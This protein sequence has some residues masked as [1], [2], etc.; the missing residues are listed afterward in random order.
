M[1]VTVAKPALLRNLADFVWTVAI[2]KVKK[3]HDFDFLC[4]VPYA[5]LPVTTWLSVE[6][7]EPML[8]KRKEAKKYGTKK[9]I[10]GDFEEGQSCL[11]VEDVIT[12]GASIFEAT[13]ALAEVGLK[14]HD[15]VVLIDREQGGREAI[16]AQ[17]F[18]MHSLFTITQIAEILVKRGRLEKDVFY[19]IADYVRENQ[20]AVAQSHAGTSVLKMDFD[21]RSKATINKVSYRLLNLM[22]AK[23]T[24]LCVAVDV[25]KSEDLLR[26]ADAVGP[27][28]CMLKTHIEILEDFTKE[29][30][31]E[32][33]TLAKKYNFL[34][35][36]DSKFG[37]IGNTVKHQYAHGVHR[38]ADW[39][40]L[41]TAHPVPGAGVIDALREVGKELEQDRGILLVVEMS[42]KGN[43]ANQHYT[44]KGCDMAMSNLDVVSGLISQHNH[45][46]NVPGL[47]TMTPGVKLQKG[48]DDLGQ[49]YNTPEKVICE[50][51]ADI[52]I[53]GRGVSQAE[54]PAK[55]AAKYKEQAWEAFQHRLTNL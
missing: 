36:Q 55:E 32:L 44:A 47:L 41:V 6:K 30:V 38:I 12:S 40:D 54:D 46:H 15:V 53:V 39:A 11:I 49:Q 33:H 2:S 45:I 42:S 8:I 24:N 29:T 13:E 31:T 18:R 20:I 21:E 37:D 27:H 16:E 25:T 23:K 5:A 50:Q 19:R 10:E 51:G 7:G 48:G 14:V 26:L 28:I 34:I 43:L 9:L 1:R 17:G 4:A 52:I 22:H 35:F 3:E